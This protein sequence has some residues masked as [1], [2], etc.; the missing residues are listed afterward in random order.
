MKQVLMGLAA[1]LLALQAMAGTIV[2]GPAAYPLGRPAAPQVVDVALDAGAFC[3]GK[4]SFIL[5]VANDGVASGRVML[6]GAAIVRERDFHPGQAPFDVPVTLGPSNV[7]SVELTGGRTGATVTLTITRELSEG[8]LPPQSFTV[9]RG[10]Q[11]SALAF[12]A[13]LP[14]EPHLLVV[15]SAEARPAGLR[16]ALNGTDVLT[17]NAYAA[18]GALLRIPVAVRFANALELDLNGPAGSAV[19]VSVRRLADESVCGPRVAITAPPAGAIISSGRLDVQGTVTGTPGAGVTVNGM[20]AD[21]DLAHAGTATDPFQWFVTIE[22]DPGNVTL[23]AV[24]VNEAGG[25][26]NDSR[27]VTFAPPPQRLT[28][29]PGTPG[30]PAPLRAAFNFALEGVDAFERFEADLDGDGVY[31]S[32]GATLSPLEA[33]YATPGVRTVRARAILTDGRVLADSVTVVVQSFAAVN[34]VLQERWRGFTDAL[35][36]GNISAALPYLGS[37]AR[38]KYQRGLTLIESNLE[39]FGASIRTIRPLWVTGSAAEY[40]LTRDVDGTLQGYYVHFARD[41]NGVWRIVQ[42]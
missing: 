9:E 12:D 26:G 25:T 30:G 3:D 10:V 23:I 41:T 2:F 20:R 17:A 22:A 21:L 42:F 11:H 38:E 33:T 24:A 29:I 37:R 40:L 34:A 4:A 6:N 39:A 16:I 15:E 14:A 28:I 35:A 36:A 27:T 1:Q 13:P 31:E 32:A 8:V 7:L 19:S 5:T 18:G